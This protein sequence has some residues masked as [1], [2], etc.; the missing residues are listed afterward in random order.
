MRF[1]RLLKKLDMGK[2]MMILYCQLVLSMM[3][4]SI[5]PNLSIFLI[6]KSVHLFFDCL[7]LQLEF[8]N[9]EKRCIIKAKQELK[10]E[11]TSVIYEFAE[12]EESQNDNKTFVGKVFNK[13]EEK[14]GRNRC[15]AATLL[16]SVITVLL[17][18]SK[19]AELLCN[20]IC[21]AYPVVKSLEKFAKLNYSLC[22][23]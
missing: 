12:E 14:T 15:E 21:F 20:S 6:Y 4:N 16:A 9:T 13:I 7:R 19:S 11:R 10:Y 1:T 22:A 3:S 18:F 5:C 2:A 8:S 23:I 17:L